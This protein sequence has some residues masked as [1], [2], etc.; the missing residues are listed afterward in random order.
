[1]KPGCEIDTVTPS[2]CELNHRTRRSE[3]IWDDER[4]DSSPAPP[5]RAATARTSIAAT[6]GTVDTVIYPI[7][8]ISMYVE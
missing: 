7:D 5:A 2:T 8:K 4:G 3:E 1:M 6:T